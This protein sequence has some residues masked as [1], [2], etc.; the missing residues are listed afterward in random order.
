MPD[1]EIVKESGSEVKDKK[2]NLSQTLEKMSP[3]SLFNVI[4]TNAIKPIKKQYLMN[5]KKN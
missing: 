4:K 5:F 3:S 2:N 1:N